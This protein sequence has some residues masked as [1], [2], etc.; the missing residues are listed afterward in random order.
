MAVTYSK[1]GPG[2]SGLV[3]QVKR[4]VN[5]DVLVGIPAEKTLRQGE[6][7]NNASLLFIHTHGSP[8]NN[9]P[10]RPVLEPSIEKNKKLITPHLGVAAKEV[11]QGHPE[12]AMRELD[13]AGMIAANGAKRYFT[14]PTNGWPPNAPSTIERKGSDRPLIDK[15]EMRR[16]ITWVVRDDGKKH[17]NPSPGGSAAEG[18]ADVI[19]DVL[20]K[21]LD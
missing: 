11:I 3:S 13:R 18:L 19:A 12:A 2:I 9:I 17:E 1:K 4:L 16:S 14:D 21:L 15:G 6:P 5:A 7:I 10:A 8:L 20:G